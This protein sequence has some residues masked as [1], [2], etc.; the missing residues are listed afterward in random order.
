M[1]GKEHQK[2][3]RCE[4]SLQASSHVSLNKHQ[5]RFIMITL[6]VFRILL[7]TLLLQVYLHDGGKSTGH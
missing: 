3:I 1:A 4:D 2:C 7:K 6:D 5:A